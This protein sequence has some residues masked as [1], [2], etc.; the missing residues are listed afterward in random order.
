MADGTI[1]ADTLV[2]TDG[3]D[4]WTRYEEVQHQCLWPDSD[5]DEAVIGPIEAD[6]LYYEV[7][8]GENAEAEIGA[9]AGLVADGTITAGTK[10]HESRG[11]PCRPPPFQW[12][13]D[14]LMPPG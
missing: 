14:Q 4:A 13:H 6:S 7:G 11:A 3:M 5:E 10:V 8:D 12:R 2:W 9:V 1:D